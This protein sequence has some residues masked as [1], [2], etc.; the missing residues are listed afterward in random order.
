[1]ATS[2]AAP[3]GDI[4]LRACFERILEKPLP[5][6]SKNPHERS[7]KTSR[8]KERDLQMILLDLF[9]GRWGWSRAFAKRGWWCIGV[10]LMRPPEI[11]RRCEFIA[12]NVMNL[13]TCHG[14]IHIMASGEQIGSHGK[15]VVVDAI[16][17]SSPC[18][19]FSV[20]GMKHFHPN[21]KYPENGIR[22]FNYTRQLCEAAGVPYV[23]ENVRGAQQFVGYAVHHCGPFY[24]WGNA[25]PP[26]MN[27][28]I[29]KG[30][31]RKAL[32]FREYK[33]EQ[34]WNKRQG[35]KTRNDKEQASR[36]ATIPPELANCVSDYFERI[37]EKAVAKKEQKTA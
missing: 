36:A 30:M 9:C 7:C 12:A 11:P 23:M 21:P 24:L 28:G 15:L 13:R 33:G 18:E 27:Q 2:R 37:L 19:E 26:L 17:A 16:V 32:G 22:L 25:V 4:S 35:M 6:K 29:T 1:M 20:Y 3:M 8:P 31:T 14:A 34:G 5:R 10:D